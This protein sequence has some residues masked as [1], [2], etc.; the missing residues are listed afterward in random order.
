MS[1]LKLAADPANLKLLVGIDYDDV[2]SKAMLDHYGF[3]VH[4]FGEE[5]IT[6]GE[7]ARIMAESIDADIYLA[8]VDYWFCLTPGWDN[9]LRQVMANNEVAN[10]A[11]V[12]EIMSFN[13]TA[14]SKKWRDLANPLES[15]LFPFWFCDQWRLEMACF[16][17]NKSP[18]LFHNISCYGKH[19]RTNNLYELTWWWGLFHALRPLRL[20]QCHMIAKAYGYAP[21]DW[22]EYIESRRKQIDAYTALDHNK[23]GSLQQL[24]QTFGDIRPKSLK[25]QK[26]KARAEQYIA[27]EGLELWKM[28]PLIP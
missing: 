3:T 15:P 28:K 25:Y 21:A 26:A 18:E 16:V 10:L 22:N 1:W 5:V 2:E 7:R 27:D 12:H 20:K 19:E 11:C 17:F 4:T 14:I 13:F 23:R 6:N 24:E 8:I 9:N